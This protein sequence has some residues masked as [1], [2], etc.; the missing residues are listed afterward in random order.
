ME[1]L[2]QTSSTHCPNV[3]VMQQFIQALGPANRAT[4]RQLVEQ[5]PRYPVVSLNDFNGLLQKAGFETL[6]FRAKVP[7]L[8]QLDG[9]L[10]G[11]LKSE[12]DDAP[13]FVVIRGVEG[14]RVR[15]FSPYAGNVQEPL[16]AFAAKW[17]GALLL[18]KYPEECAGTLFEAQDKESAA[19]EEYR[20][21]HIRLYDDFLTPAECRYIIRYAEENRL[22]NR[23]EVE[24]NQD[25]G[26]VSSERTSYSASLTKLRNDP[27]LKPIY[28]RVSDW[29]KV[30]Q[31]YIE[32]LQ[33]VRYSAG[34]Q[35]KPH[36]DAGPTNHRVHTLLVYLNDDFEGGETFFP[37]LNEK[38]LPRRGRALYFLNRRDGEVILQSAHAGLPVQHGTKYGC[39]IWVRDRPAVS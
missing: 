17:T 31:T 21:Q 33:C 39:N 29:L 5:T 7:H 12:L 25:Q 1:T 3:S 4:V 38:V 28:E 23:S 26:T 15:Y 34:Q 22:F 36:Y 8:V 9:P 14:E 30:P 11:Y 24:Y 2:T 27:C 10:L 13:Y 37:E 6:A 19:V 35:F 32:H 20:S 16:A 18:A